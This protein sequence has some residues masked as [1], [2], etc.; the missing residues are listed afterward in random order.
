MKA[1]AHTSRIEPVRL[2]M[3]NPNRE[4][5]GMKNPSRLVPNRL[6]TKSL[7]SKVV[8]EAS[9][10]CRRSSLFCFTMHSSSCFKCEEILSMASTSQNQQHQQEDSLPISHAPISC[11]ES[12]NREYIEKKVL[13]EQILRLVDEVAEDSVSQKK[14]DLL[15]SAKAAL[16]KALEAPDQI[17]SSRSK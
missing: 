11:Q 8:S 7:R 15:K 2:R 14:K 10:D 4:V 17:S 3:K 1:L 13:K 9:S 16:Q 5:T 12:S 6:R